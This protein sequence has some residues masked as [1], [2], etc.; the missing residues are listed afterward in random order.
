MKNLEPKR[1]ELNHPTT[2]TQWLRQM[3]NYRPAVERIFGHFQQDTG[4][5]HYGEI[6]KNTFEEIRYIY[7]LMNII[8]YLNFG[9]FNSVS[10]VY[11]Q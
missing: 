4:D 10:Y 2:R 5:S 1:D 6:C 11:K 9:Y 3:C 8:V 7:Y